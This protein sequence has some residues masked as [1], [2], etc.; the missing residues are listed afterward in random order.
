MSHEICFTESHSWWPNLS[1]CF[2]MGMRKLILIQRRNLIHVNIFYM[3]NL[4]IYYL[5]VYITILFYLLNFCG[6][7]L[8]TKEWCWCSWSRI[9][10]KISKVFRHLIYLCCRP[11]SPA[12]CWG[13]M[14][15]ITT[16][17]GTSFPLPKT[18]QLPLSCIRNTKQSFAVSS[19]F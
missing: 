15:S 12:V 4:D 5:S 6:Y 2:F 14:K 13:R 18:R 19:N 7:L 10:L 11:T 9:L 16:P 17:L 1:R 3:L 8:S